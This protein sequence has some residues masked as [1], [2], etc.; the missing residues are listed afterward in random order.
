M[1]GYSSSATLPLP[2][3]ILGLSP[4]AWITRWD[5]PGF[6]GQRLRASSSALRQVAA[7]QRRPPEL[8]E[9]VLELV[10]VVVVARQG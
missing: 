8:S 3:T 6:I 10:L 2:S 5:D 7:G 1:L 4:N 9:L